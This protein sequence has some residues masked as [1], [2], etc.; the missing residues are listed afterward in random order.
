MIEAVPG[1]GFVTGGSRPAVVPRLLSA[2]GN[3][4]AAV[5][6]T[7]ILAVLLIVP[8]LIQPQLLAAFGNGLAGAG[9]VMVSGVLV[10][11]MVAFA[12]QAV[13]QAMQG[14]ISIRFATKISIRMGTFDADP[15]IRPSA[16]SYV[17]YAAPWE[18]IPDDGL[19]RFPEARKG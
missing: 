5:V 17:A 18:P 13:L 12:L 15:G 9:A 7:T 16:R 6:L 3:V 8:T 11:L 4:T 10:G 1:E 19:P 14:L 2:A